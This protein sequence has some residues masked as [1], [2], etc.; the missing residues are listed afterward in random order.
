MMALVAYVSSGFLDDDPTMVADNTD[1]YPN[2]SASEVI[3]ELGYSL[4][5]GDDSGDS[6]Q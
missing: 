1:V 5:V 2:T 6:V 3:S 4:F